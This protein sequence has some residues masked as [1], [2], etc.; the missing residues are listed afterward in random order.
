MFKI[1]G[2]VIKV[3]ERVGKLKPYTLVYLEQGM[4]KNN[5][6]VVVPTQVDKN[7]R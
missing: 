6:Y 7:V 2:N 3:E 5:R 4:F 1:A